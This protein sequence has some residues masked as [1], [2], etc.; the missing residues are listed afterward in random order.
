M[1]LS[2]R[3][4]IRILGEKNNEVVENRK[5]NNKMKPLEHLDDFLDAIRTGRTPHADIAEGVRSV[6]PIHLANIALR[7]GRS[8]DFDPVEQKIIGN[9]EANQLLSRAY[10]KGGHWAVPKGV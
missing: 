8:L 9:E 7:T 10:R 4:K 5:V 3:G 2:K 6:A 1:F